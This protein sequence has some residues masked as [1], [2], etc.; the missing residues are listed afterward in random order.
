[1]TIISDWGSKRIHR[2]SGVNLLSRFSTLGT[3]GMG[4]QDGGISGIS[5]MGTGNYI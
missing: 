1:M 3:G 2:A 4:I 5:I